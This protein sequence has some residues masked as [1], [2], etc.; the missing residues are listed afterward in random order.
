M[1]NIMAHHT[2]NEVKKMTTIKWKFSTRR[3]AEEFVI[4]KPDEDGNVVIQSNKTIAQINLKTGKGILNAK[5]SNSK[6]FMHLNEFMG[7]RYTKFSPILV[8]KIKNSMPKSG[9]RIG[10]GIYWA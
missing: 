3:K 9:D 6:Y 2:G 5:G 4:Y 10:K 1:F 8:N 7:A